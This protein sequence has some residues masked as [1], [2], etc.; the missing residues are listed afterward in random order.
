MKLFQNTENKLKANFY[1]SSERQNSAA[2]KK[3]QNMRGFNKNKFKS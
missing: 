3:C 2:R 1:L